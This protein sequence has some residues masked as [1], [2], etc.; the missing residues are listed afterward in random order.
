MTK[1]KRLSILKDFSV[2]YPAKY[3]SPYSPPHTPVTMRPKTTA[4]A[5]YP[6]DHQAASLMVGSWGVLT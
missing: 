5:T 3:S 2:M 4:T 1:T 6:T